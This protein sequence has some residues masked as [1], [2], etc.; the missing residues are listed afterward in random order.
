MNYELRI[1]KNPD[2]ISSINVSIFVG[3]EVLL[4][5]FMENGFY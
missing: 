5:S 1:K 3:N 4:I 2:S